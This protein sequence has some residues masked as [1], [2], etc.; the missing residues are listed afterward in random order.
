MNPAYKSNSDRAVEYKHIVQTCQAVS[1]Q[2][3]QIINKANGL[4]MWTRQS[5]DVEHLGVS[6]LDNARQFLSEAAD[7]FQHAANIFSGGSYY[8]VGRAV[9][10]EP[11]DTTYAEPFPEPEKPEEPAEP[12]DEE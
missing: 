9:A 4:M 10:A 1:E 8:R 2:I 6:S 11:K 7:H 3:T 12:E 5:L